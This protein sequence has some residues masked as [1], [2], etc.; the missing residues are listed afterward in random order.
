MQ[1]W[2]CRKNG[3]V[4]ANLRTYHGFQLSWICIVAEIFC[5][6]N[7][8]YYD[9]EFLFRLENMLRTL[10][11]ENGV[12]QRWKPD[13]ENFRL[14]RDEANDRQKQILLYKVHSKVV[15]RWFLLSLK[16]KY[17]GIAMSPF[18]GL[19]M[20]IICWC[21]SRIFW[22]IV[23]FTVLTNVSAWKSAQSIEIT[24]WKFWK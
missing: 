11:L 19:I 4:D 15:E 6:E 12:A 7:W 8:S 18:T 10:V 21:F 9:Y 3:L 23:F 5:V 24:R 13:D 17:A 22:S 2:T 1:S 16:A 14:A 20:L